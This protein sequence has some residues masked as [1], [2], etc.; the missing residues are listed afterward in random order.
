M[1]WKPNKWIATI[2]AFLFQPLGMLYVARVKLAILYFLIVIV[3]SLLE[4]YLI[5][6]SNRLWTEYITLIWFVMIVC[7]VHA[8][9]IAVSF[10]G[11]KEERPW[12]SKWYGLVSFP[13]GIFIGVLFI[14]S[15][16]YE[17]F[18]L[19]STSMYPTI[20]RNSHVIVS[21][22]GYGYYESFGISILKTPATKTIN[23]GDLVVFKYPKDPSID[24][25]K[26]IIGLPGDKIV[27]KNK[28]LYINGEKSSL[29][30]LSE[31]QTY[32]LFE[33]SVISSTYKI[34]HSPKRKSINE[35]YTVPD[36]HYFVMGDNRDN[37]NDSRFWGYVP[38]SNIVGKVV[39]IFK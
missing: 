38:K 39:Y 33:E 11:V 9:R 8:H 6:S 30:K 17:P 34:A 21:K 35:E 16:L 37:S 12:Y 18:R 20:P 22:Y 13:I 25:I 26:R 4:L 10:E 1:S 23:R 27:Y 2:L 5:S 32:E 29:K 28:N 15:F 24:Y 36:G 31:N 19:P 14:R 3:I 7:A